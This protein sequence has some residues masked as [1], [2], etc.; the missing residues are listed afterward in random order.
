MPPPIITRQSAPIAYVGSPLNGPGD[1]GWSSAMA[2]P[3]QPAPEARLL[4][5]GG[6]WHLTTAF[7]RGFVALA[8]GAP[9]GTTQRE[10]APG[11]TVIR[12]PPAADVL[13]QFRQRYGIAGDRALVVVR[14]DGYVFGRWNDVDLD[15]ARAALQARGVQ[16]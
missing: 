5:D 12:V 4:G 15:A 14:P 1:G 9:G 7:G 2:A 13:G 11:F 8:W 6:E 16:P 10:L 3:G